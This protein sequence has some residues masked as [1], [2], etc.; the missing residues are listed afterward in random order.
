MAAG[1]SV[2]ATSF[3]EL[4]AGIDLRMNWQV[5]DHFADTAE[6]RNPSQV[7]AKDANHSCSSGMSVIAID[8]VP[9]DGHPSIADL[10]TI[11]SL[12]PLAGLQ[13]IQVGSRH[14]NA[15]TT[16]TKGSARAFRRAFD[17]Q[18]RCRLR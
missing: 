16:G 14:Q 13:G 3:S 17:W 8:C 5:G 2:M 12:F 7:A 1:A 9:R 15:A 6:D 10:F 4:P 11:S 18:Q